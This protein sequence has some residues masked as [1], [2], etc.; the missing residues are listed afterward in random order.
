VAPTDVGTLV[1]IRLVRSAPA[2]DGPRPA[3]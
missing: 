3:G 1:V 2:P